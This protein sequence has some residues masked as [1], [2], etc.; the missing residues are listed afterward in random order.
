MAD[1]KG[2]W[3]HQQPPNTSPPLPPPRLTR[4]V[5]GPTS[6]PPILHKT[7]PTEPKFRN[8]KTTSKA[9]VRGVDPPSLA[10]LSSV[11]FAI[12]EGEGVLKMDEPVSTGAAAT[13]SAPPTALLLSTLDH[14]A[15]LKRLRMARDAAC[16]GRPSSPQELPPWASLCCESNG[17]RDAGGHWVSDAE[18]WTR[19]ERNAS[20]PPP[21]PPGSAP[22]S[23]GRWGR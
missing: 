5:L 11:G 8:I 23:N 1:P 19:A 6:S 9:F 10:L 15:T 21:P 22:S 7:F 20:M 16:Y 18:V 13:P 17:S 3:A 12:H 14:L 2:T 4:Q